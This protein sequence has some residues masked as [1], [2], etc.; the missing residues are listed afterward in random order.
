MKAFAELFHEDATWVVWTGRVWKGRKAIEEGHV[1]AHRTFFRNSTQ[2]SEP[3]EI[4][5]IAPDVVV[6]RSRTTLSGD[7]RDPDSQIHGLKLLVI[8]R[9]RGTWKILYGQN[10]RVTPAVLQGR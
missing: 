3:V 10:T 2:L 6:A 9:R 5:Q 1:D 8:T 4:N 7:A